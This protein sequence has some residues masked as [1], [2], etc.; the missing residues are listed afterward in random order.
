MNKSTTFSIKTKLLALVGVAMLTLVGMAFYTHN[1]L[2]NLS[3]DMKHLGEERIPIVQTLADIREAQQAIPRFFWLAHLS[4]INSEVRAKS[5]I[6]LAEYRKILADETAELAT[7]QYPENERAQIKLIQ[8]AIPPY[9]EIAEKGYNLLKESTTVE[10]DKAAVAW[11]LSAVPPVAIKLSEALGAIGK[12]VSATNQAEVRD[13][14]AEAA[15]A[16]KI[17]TLVS[18]IASLLLGVFGYFFASSLAKSLSAISSMIGESSAQVASAAAQVSSS[19][20]MLASTSTE[21]ASAVEETSA[22]L[23]EMTGMVE[24]TVRYSETGLQSV[25][26]VKTVSGQGNTSMQS[27]GAAMEQVMAS[28]KRI[29]ELVKVIGEIGEK[30]EIIDEIVFQTKLLSFNASVEAERA[31]EHGRGFAVVAQ[32]VGNLAQMSGKAALEISSIVKSSTKQ[33]QEIAN[34]NKE[35]VLKGNEYVEETAGYLQQIEKSADSVL[36]GSRQI[37]SASKEQSAGIKQITSAMENINKATQETAA[38]SEEAASA[39]EELN[40]QARHLAKLVTDLNTLITG[41]SNS[42]GPSQDA[43]ETTA[44]RTSN[45]YSLEHTKK[46]K[47]K[48]SYAAASENGPRFKK[49]VGDSSSGTDEVA[50]N[51]GNNAW[52]KL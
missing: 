22:S 38:T 8:A 9:L 2:N 29:E 16:I 11:L 45:V 24:N 25:E 4:G 42:S 33:A 48:P 3:G 43:L 47:K 50:A 27:L 18:A 5:F 12:D 7:L 20:Q 35:R 28:N 40:A 34:E 23:E 1:I 31:G 14:E 46:A 30:T 10:K 36:N 41:S 37:L 52:D 19:S 44:P 13:S 39:G 17:S 49:A 15:W 21:Q 26:G 51:T 32:E 6:K